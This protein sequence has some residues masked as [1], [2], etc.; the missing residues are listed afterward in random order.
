MP[1]LVCVLPNA[2]EA[3]QLTGKR[4][5]S[6]A[7]PSLLCLAIRSHHMPGRQHQHIAYV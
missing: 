7:M 3:V 6:V 5:M 1:S 4:V 2:D